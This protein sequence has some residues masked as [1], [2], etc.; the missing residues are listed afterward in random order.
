MWRAPREQ[1][2]K[3]SLKTSAFSWGELATL[4]SG[5]FIF[6]SAQGFVPHAVHSRER[7]DHLDS[8]CQLCCAQCAQAHC[9]WLCSPYRSS[10]VLQLQ[11]WAVFHVMGLCWWFIQEPVSFWGQGPVWS[12]RD[13]PDQ[14][15]QEGQAGETDVKSLYIS[16]PPLYLVLVGFWWKAL[17]I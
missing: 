4:P 3:W 1:F 13:S 17:L 7:L 12:W 14:V 5:F 15:Q 2:L 6:P 11:L 10:F 9:Q 8:R 16:K